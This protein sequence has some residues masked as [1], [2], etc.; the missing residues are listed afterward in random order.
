MSTEQNPIQTIRTELTARPPCNHDVVEAIR[1]AS[2]TPLTY[3]DAVIARVAWSVIVEPGDPEAGTLISARGPVAALALVLNPSTG[4]VPD[5]LARLAGAQYNPSRVARRLELAVKHGFTVLTPEDVGWP[6]RL[7]ALGDATPLLLWC[8]GNLEALTAEDATALTGSRAATSYGEHVTMNLTS[9]LVA[10]EHVI[11]TG[12]AYG[13]EGM[14]TR[15]ALASGGRPVVVLAGGVDRPYPSGHHDLI[16]RVATNGGVVISELPPTTAPTK[17]RF[18]ARNRII[19]ALADQVVIVE[20]GSRSGSLNTAGHANSI[21]KPVYAVPGP[22][23][24]P[25]SAGCHQ[26]IREG[27]ARLAACVAEMS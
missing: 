25:T 14:A 17:W 26:L 11:I 22:I 19:A 9:D 20:A 6:T 27:R 24:S 12:A 18:L 5:R 10:N 2:S 15:I 13:I 21:G 7:A 8:R 3:S 1:R 16:T 4:V 23:T